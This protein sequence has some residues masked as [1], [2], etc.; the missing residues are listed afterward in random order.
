MINIILIEPISNQTIGQCVLDMDL[1][2]M[3]LSN[4]KERT[5]LCE[6]I[7]ESIEQT[8]KPNQGDKHE[9]SC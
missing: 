7:L 9:H 3:D 8:I 2:Q 5:L 6:L 4:P 1:K